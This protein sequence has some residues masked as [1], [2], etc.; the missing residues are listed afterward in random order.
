MSPILS[1]PLN[2]CRGR[3]CVVAT[4]SL[5]LYRLI[6]DQMMTD[7][8]TGNAKQ[9]LNILPMTADEYR[10][11]GR[12][13]TISYSFATTQYGDILIASTGRGV[14]ALTFVDS[15]ADAI[16]HLHSLYPS[17]RFVEQTTDHHTAALHAIDGPC[18]DLTLHLRVT[19]FQLAVWQAL[20]TIPRGRTTT[21]SR[22]AEHIG[23]P[24][25]SRAVG[26]AVGQNP[27]AILI[28]CHRVVRAD[29]TLGGY[30]WSP[31]RKHAILS[32]EI[33]GLLPFPD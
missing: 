25:A 20:L 1:R 7:N 30:R 19:P 15:P 13:L 14:C 31:S 28:P 3:C 5:S 4:H 12:Q 6:P 10:D 18:A 33:P 23:R 17:A 21:Y 8:L 11:G 9:C 27:V 29:G 24:T 26:N 16:C 22:I 32:S 2:N